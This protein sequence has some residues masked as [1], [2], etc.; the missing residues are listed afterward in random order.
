MVTDRDGIT[1]AIFKSGST[2]AEL[3]GFVELSDDIDE[4]VIVLDV[5]ED[6][7]VE[8]MNSAADGIREFCEEF[9]LAPNVTITSARVKDESTELS[10]KLCGRLLIMNAMTDNWNWHYPED[11]RSTTNGHR[12]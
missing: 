12:T 8:F 5:R 7:Q 3:S 11:W 6:V 9:D 1:R 4:C 2:F 10:F